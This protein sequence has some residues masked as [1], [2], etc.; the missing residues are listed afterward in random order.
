M[1]NLTKFRHLREFGIFDDISPKER[2]SSSHK[3]VP[4]KR[5][6]DESGQFGENDE[7]DDIS[8]KIEIRANEL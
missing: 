2:M 7:F 8:P 3:M 5:Q 1:A 4:T 6:F